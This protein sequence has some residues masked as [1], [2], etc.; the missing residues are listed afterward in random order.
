MII[1][2]NN[3][4]KATE[5]EYVCGHDDHINVLFN[6]SICNRNIDVGNSGVSVGFFFSSSDGTIERYERKNSSHIN[7]HVES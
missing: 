1:Y 2:D 7:M 3:I 5:E 6:H 4:E